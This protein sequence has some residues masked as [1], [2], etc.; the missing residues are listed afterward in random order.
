MS[1]RITPAT[2]TIF[3]VC[4][5]AWVGLAFAAAGDCILRA[6]ESMSNLMEA[7][8]FNR[9]QWLI[10]IAITGTVEFIWAIQA[11]QDGVRKSLRMTVPKFQAA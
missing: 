1:N 3:T 8:D 5:A 10:T 4:R 2:Q 9:W 6:T 11:F 7:F